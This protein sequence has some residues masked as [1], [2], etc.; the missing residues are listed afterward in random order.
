MAVPDLDQS[1]WQSEVKSCISREILKSYLRTQQRV[2]PGRGPSIRGFSP[3]E[4]ELSYYNQ[5]KILGSCGSR[6]IF[7]AV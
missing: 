5:D 1:L 6:S 3:A 7:V 2:W 4:L